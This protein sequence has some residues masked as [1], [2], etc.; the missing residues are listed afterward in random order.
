MTVAGWRFESSR[1]HH[2]VPR[3][4]RFPESVRKAPE[5]ATTVDNPNGANGTFVRDIND[6]VRADLTGD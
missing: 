2:A 3:Y 4:R 6:A 5:L 1:A